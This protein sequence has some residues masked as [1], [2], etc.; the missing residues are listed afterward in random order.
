MLVGFP[1]HVFHT[2]RVQVLGGCAA[3]CAG[4]AQ[5]RCRFIFNRA[6]ALMNP[7]SPDDTLYSSV[8]FCPS[9]F[10]QLLSLL[11]PQPL[12]KCEFT[13][14]ACR[15]CHPDVDE[16]IHISCTGEATISDVILRVS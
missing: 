16:H 13:I 14:R 7:C 9:L 4:A 5:Q 11:P 2:L 12:H 10:V 6:R 1:E 15:T 3:A 8:L